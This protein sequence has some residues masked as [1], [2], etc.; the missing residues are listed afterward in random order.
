MHKGRDTKEI[1]ANATINFFQS[2]PRD[3]ELKTTVVE[4]IKIGISEL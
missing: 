3:F 4:A 1:N 2:P